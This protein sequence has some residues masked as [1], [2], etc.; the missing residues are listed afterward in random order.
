MPKITFL[1]QSGWLFESPKA[2]IVID[3]FLEGNPLAVHKAA[4]IKADYILISHAHGDHVAD[5]EPIAK[6]CKSTIIANFEIA[7]YYENKGFE[8]H[9]LHIGGG[10]NFPFGRVK[11]TPAFHGS[12]FPDGTYGGMP[13]GI[14]LTIDDK[15]FYHTGDTA[16]FSDMQLIGKHNL[17]DVMMVCIG[18]NFTMGIDDAV[19]AVDLVKPRLTIPM[20]Y[21]TFPYIE[22]DPEEFASKTISN[23]NEVKILSVGDSINL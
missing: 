17:V 16:L 23:G 13:A 20:H 6:N 11:L 3:P 22:V 9:P 15:V 10:N 19:E 12:S 1:G 4:D 8:M 14:L 7:S 5:V 21:K 2:N 18:D